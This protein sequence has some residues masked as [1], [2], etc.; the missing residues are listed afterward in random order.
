MGKVSHCLL[1]SACLPQ[2]LRVMSTTQGLWLLCEF[3]EDVIT[4]HHDLGDISLSGAWKSWFR[5][6]SVLVPSERCEAEFPPSYSPSSWWLISNHW[7]FLAY[8]SLPSFHLASHLCGLL[9]PK[10]L[11]SGHQS[12]WVGDPPYSVC[13]CVCVCVCVHALSRSRIWSLATPWT[14]A[15][16]APLSMGIF[17][18]RILEWVAISSC[19]DQTQG[20]N[21]RLFNLLHWQAGSLPLHHPGN[22]LLALVWLILTNYILQQLCCQIWSYPEVKGLGF[23][24]VDGAG[25]GHSLTFTS[26][27]SANQPFRH[28]KKLVLPW[29]F[30]LFNNLQLLARLFC[31][32]SLFQTHLCLGQCLRRW[33]PASWAL[34]AHSPSPRL[35]FSRSAL[36]V[37]TLSCLNVQSLTLLILLV[38]VKWI[39][40]KPGL[41]HP[42][43]C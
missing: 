25:A 31:S 11:L 29:G 42:V 5:G 20:S 32:G 8:R 14:V 33:H 27:S 17:Q 41:L 21:L 24:H 12:Y 7:Y 39:A 4:E 28:K 22:L 40:L 38:S 16:E 36:W 19:R 9:S 1:S 6:L 18:A 13:V 2:P 3:P 37:H 26:P 35:C 43:R 10:F 34:R 30:F 15:H 23:Q